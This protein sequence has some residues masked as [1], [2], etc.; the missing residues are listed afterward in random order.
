[1]PA[2]WPERYA[3]RAADD[4]LPAK[5]AERDASA[6]RVG[7]DGWALPDG[8]DADDAPPGLAELPAI[9][10]PRRI[11]LGLS[12]APGP[13]DAARPAGAPWLRVVAIVMTARA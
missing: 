8:L 5:Q 3:R 2:A 1:M 9:R 11:R 4:R 10:L 12:V 7:A 13:L 6:S